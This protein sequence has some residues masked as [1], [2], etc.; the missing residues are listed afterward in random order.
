MSVLLQTQEDLLNKAQ[1][2]ATKGIFN[3]LPGT[4]KFCQDYTQVIILQDHLKLSFSE[5]NM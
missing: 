4:L 2:D 1:L 3:L 5:Q